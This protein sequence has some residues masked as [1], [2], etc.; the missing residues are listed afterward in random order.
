MA[1]LQPLI[2]RSDSEFGVGFYK[3]S[4]ELNPQVDQGEITV[5][6][7]DKNEVFTLSYAREN[8]KIRITAGK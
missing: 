1:A 4:T 6:C 3:F 7:A 8:G 5:K 2:A